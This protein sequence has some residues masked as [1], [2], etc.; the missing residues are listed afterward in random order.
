MCGE[1]YYFMICN[2]LICS[3][4]FKIHM[5]CIQERES[6]CV[7]AQNAYQHL[8]DDFHR[9]YTHTLTCKHER[10]VGVHEYGHWYSQ[11]ICCVESVRQKLFFGEEQKD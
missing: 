1:V 2:R 5:T 7:N 10:I 11:S 6:V 3:V 9:E 8:L 4:I